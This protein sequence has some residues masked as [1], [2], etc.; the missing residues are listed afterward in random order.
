MGLN[1]F[2]HKSVKNTYV[3]YWYFIVKPVLKS[4]NNYNSKCKT[5]FCKSPTERAMLK[6]HHFMMKM[7]YEMSIAVRNVKTFNQGPRTF[8]SV[9][10]YANL[11]VKDFFSGKKT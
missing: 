7:S 6:S 1:V 10:D 2:N 11:R 4:N 8:S 9:K 3:L 5:F